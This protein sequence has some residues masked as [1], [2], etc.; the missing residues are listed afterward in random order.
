MIKSS[1]FNIA[2]KALPKS[3]L[4]TEVECKNNISSLIVDVVQSGK[5]LRSNSL[6]TLNN[7]STPFPV[8]KRPKYPN[9]YLVRFLL[10]AGKNIS[11]LKPPD[12]ETKIL[13][14]C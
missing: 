11:G 2:A 6:K 14:D 12:G 3:F 1:F 8:S 5:T 13:S 7:V 10:G 4:A 9:L